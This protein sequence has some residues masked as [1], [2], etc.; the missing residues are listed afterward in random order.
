MEIHR[1][2]STI[3]DHVSC[4]ECTLQMISVSMCMVLS[5]T[6]GEEDIPFFMSNL[7]I[8]NHIFVHTPPTYLMDVHCSRS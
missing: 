4:L 3:G 6:Y 1:L 8:C 2:W 5:V 7:N